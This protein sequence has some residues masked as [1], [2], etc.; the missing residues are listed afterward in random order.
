[1]VVIFA[2][3]L[4]V[5][6][7]GAII[8]TAS[9]GSSWIETTQADFLQGT[10]DNVTVNSGGNVTLNVSSQS[11][12]FTS[13]P[14]D[15]GGANMKYKTINW[16][17]VLPLD[18]NIQFQLKTAD[19]LS[20]LSLNNFVGPD[21]STASHYNISSGE[22]IWSGHDGMQWIQYR[23]TLS[24]IGVQLPVLEHVRIYYNFIP[25]APV[26]IA[27]FND[28][29]ISSS[30]P[31]FNWT[32]S[33]SDGTSGGFEVL[34]DNDSGFSSV[35][36]DSGNQSSLDDYWQFPN[37][38]GYSE[39]PDGVWY[40]KVRVK[41]NDNDTSEFSLPYKFKIDSAPPTSIITAPVNSSYLSSLSSIS[42]T[43]FDV[44]GSGLKNV[45]LSIR[46]NSDNQYWDGLLWVPSEVF[47]PVSGSTS[48]SKSAGLPVWDSGKNYT[49]RSQATDNAS[50]VEISG[51]EITFYFDS[52][53]PWST[54]LSPADGS[55]HNNLTL[56]LGTSS[57]A[58]G[59]LVDFVEISIR[60][61]SDNLY[62]NGTD[63]V[64]SEIWLLTS[65]TTSWS[66]NSSVPLWENDV[67]YII[68]SRA[69]DLALNSESPGFGNVFTF[70]IL[71]PPPPFP[72]VATPGGW[73]NN[74]SFEI[75]WTD[76]A[77]TSGAL[78]GAYYKFNSPPTSDTDGIWVGEKPITNITVPFEG[79]HTIYIWLKD[80]VGNVNYLNYST[81]ILYF[82]AQIFAPQNLTAQPSGWTKSNSFSINWVDYNETSGIMGAYYKFNSPPT[83][84]TDGIWA[85]A[86]PI[87]GVSVPSEGMHTMYL[88]LS[89]NAGNIDYLRYATVN[90]SFDSQDP[91]P[92][93]DVISDPVGWTNVN[94]FDVSWTNPLD[95]SGPKGAYYKLDIPP[96]N[97]IDGDYVA[98]NDIDT[99]LDI[100][101]G[102]EGD[103][104]IYIWLEDKAGNIN[105]LNYST[106]ILYYDSTIDKPMSL[107]MDPPDWSY[108]NLFNITWTNPNEESGISGA[109]YKLHS[110]PT[111]DTDGNY[112]AG[113]GIQLIPGLSVSSNGEHAVY[114]WL[115][116]F[117]GN[118]DFTKNATTIIFYDST[119]PEKPLNLQA[120][121]EWS[122]DNSFTINWDFPAGSS[123]SGYK[124]GL[125]YKMGSAPENNEDGIWISGKPITL[126]SPSQGAHPVYIW[127]ENNAGNTS[128]LKSEEIQLKWDSENP[129]L[130]ITA[131]SEGEYFSERDVELTWNADDLQSFIANIKLKLD[132]APY[133]D[134]GSVA[135][136]T[137][138]GLTNGRHKVYLKAIDAAGNFNETSIDFSIDIIP[139]TVI[140]LEP[141]VNESFE[142]RSVFV[143]WWS[144]DS[145][146]GID[147]YE[148]SLDNGTF[149]H[150]G[151]N[152]NHT[153]S[154]LS[155]GVHK[156]V[157][158][159]FD[160][161]G[162]WVDVEIEFS[163][164]VYVVPDTDSDGLNDTVDPDDDNDGLPDSWED[165]HG[166]DRLNSSDAELDSDSDELN[167][168]ME[169]ELGTDPKNSDSDFDGHLDGEDAYPLD[170][171]KWKKEGVEEESSM[172]LVLIIV[173][174]AVVAVVLILYL[175]K[176]SR[177]GFIGFEEDE[178][179]DTDSEDED[180]EDEDFEDED[181]EEDEYEDTDFDDDDSEEERFEDLEALKPAQEDLN[182]SEE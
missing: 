178:D 164:D 74:N 68:R 38:T 65:G 149:S 102:G 34:I 159:G 36:Y 128:Y 160:I 175:M 142:T 181:S 116:D 119:E 146:S 26:L 117:A 29:W 150:V 42:G 88:W 63:W 145:G 87:L 125:W 64:G 162:N 1:M 54:I 115:V 132:D 55:Y 121:P 45:Q 61:F 70:D 47:L 100:A 62:W 31:F 73:T 11:G 60:R 32:F 20:N 154:N 170:S 166:L 66:F 113:D 126:T 108:I 131:P 107:E 106:T 114:L 39:I 101:V 46:R 151:D 19:T 139:P 137:L 134:I 41:D 5:Q 75:N 120:T 52:D 78:A 124:I 71:A 122:P 7:N 163:I 18:T 140:I 37:G 67:I 92:P 176:R 80:I 58:Q 94:S 13:A 69:R 43:S 95:A 44:N 135:S 48:W 59:G 83:S 50:N 81:T 174:I 14:F 153:F 30:T 84:D 27:P 173:V 144:V 72:V 24:T 35:N 167:N 15:C 104:I 17:E 98:G 165:L 109:Y 141:S 6:F 89:D 180:Y 90:L 23:A 76:P 79:A 25:D 147:H 21:G 51:E 172:G 10:I 158:R 110:P 130:T 138:T 148:I 179:E 118:V 77:D 155:N 129:T 8:D 152:K 136:F 9:A 49:I 111:S 40:W 99:I 169:Y 133:T 96:L 12:N 143:S 85:T 82:D 157:I 16:T 177:S 56:I 103:H 91:L 28:T 168:S 33:D 105:Y 161:A 171:D 123:P 112:I 127:L 93:L 156:V 2:V 97:D 4:M 3:I 57:D 86:R 182:D 22:P 53:N